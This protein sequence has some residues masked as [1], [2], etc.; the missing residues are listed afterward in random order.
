[1]SWTLLTNHAHVL[2]AVACDPDSR[3]RDIGDRVGITERAVHRIVCDL[4]EAGYLTRHHVGARNTYEV[5]F[6]AELRERFEHQ[7]RLADVLELLLKDHGKRLPGVSS[8]SGASR[9]ARPTGAHTDH[10]PTVS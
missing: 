4:E 10:I 8:S 1:M 5:H 9:P 2:H 7:I 6:T 3:L